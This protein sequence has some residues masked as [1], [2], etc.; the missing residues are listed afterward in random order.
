MI[1]TTADELL[2]LFR[3]D[4]HDLVDDEGDD[5][6]CLWSSRE[7]YRYM[8]VAW[9]ALLRKTK[10]HYATLPLAVTGGSASVRL[11]RHVLHVRHAV[12]ES[13]GDVLVGMTTNDYEGCLV[14]DYGVKVYQR[15]WTRH[16]PGTPRR[17]IRDYTRG[18]IVLVPEPVDDDTITAQC[19]ITIPIAMNEGIMLP[20]LAAEA[21]QLVLAHMKYQAY[22]KQDAEAENLN[23]AQ[24]FLDEY[25]LGASER[26][27][28]LANQ[29]RTPQPIRMEWM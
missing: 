3:E 12:L 2:T 27:M 16:S 18:Q 20:I 17:Y 22:R 23:R 25:N 6:N 26:E 21:H 10:E 5:S 24:K 28:E 1:A 19:S 15:D 11:P 14:D 8:T 7:G 9:D 4:V 29:R 13:T